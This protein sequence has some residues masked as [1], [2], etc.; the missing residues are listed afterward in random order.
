MAADSS[1]PGRGSTRDERSAAERLFT[2]L[3]PGLMRW[4][5]RRLPPHARRRLDTGDLVQEACV[6]ALR[7]LPDLAEYAPDVV[8]A[9]VQQAIRNR[10]RDELR[11]AALGEVAGD[12]GDPPAVDLP[13]PLDEAITAEEQRRFRRAL[14]SL[15][16]EDRELVVGRIDLGLSY[17]QL[18]AATG[19]RSADAARVAVRRAILK[20]AR[21]LDAE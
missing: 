9:Y 16:D 10:I 7:R 15:A 4:T 1:A 6:G 13:S 14:E 19:R 8:R 21:A 5:H 11:R 20:L 3:L 17:A 2:R 12:P 18:A